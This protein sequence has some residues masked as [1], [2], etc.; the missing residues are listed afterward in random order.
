MIKQTIDIRSLLK[1]AWEVYTTHFDMI[2]RLVGQWFFPVT[3]VLFM[4]I[5][6][7]LPFQPAVSEA[8]NNNQPQ[9]LQIFF[10][11]AISQISHPWTSFNIIFDGV[12]F[13]GWAA[14][15]MLQCIINTMI[16]IALVH[17][18]QTRR[19]GVSIPWKEL[20]DSS[21]SKLSRLLGVRAIIIVG[22]YLG[23]L[24]FIIPGIILEIYWTFGF[25]IAA[26]TGR[27]G[28]ESLSMSREIVRGQW[29][30]IAMMIL[31]VRLLGGLA[32]TALAVPWV[33]LTTLTTD[34]NL[35]AILNAGIQS[36][37]YLGELFLLVFEAVFLL[38]YFQ[39]ETE[40]GLEK[41]LQEYA[42]EEKLPA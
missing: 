41:Q 20:V 37:V 26:M 42:E 38:N 35:L 24:F 29:W 36:M 21:V 3:A 9:T 22:V 6:A 31:G 2:G 16:M 19:Y 27:S 33:L 1:Q 18:I 23:Y 30:K 8:I 15:Q 39:R 34:P 14:S 28:S 5:P 13:P 40:I 7:H 4:M 32:A 10:E 11:Q 12:R 25:V 17:V